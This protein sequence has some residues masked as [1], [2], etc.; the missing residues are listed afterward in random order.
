[1]KVP[2]RGGKRRGEGEGGEEKG[3]G[4]GGREME[5]RRETEERKR[6]GIVVRQVH[7]GVLV[8][9]WCVTFVHLSLLSGSPC[10]MEW[11]LCQVNEVCSMQGWLREGR[12]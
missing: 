3:R 5:G 11:V 1:M 4:E 8:C 7:G 12:R 10:G 6:A 9:V 2:G